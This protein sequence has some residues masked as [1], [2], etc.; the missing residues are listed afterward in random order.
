MVIMTSGITNIQL[1]LFLGFQKHRI[2]G[3]LL[4]IK[5]SRTPLYFGD[6][7]G[8]PDLLDG[9]HDNCSHLQSSGL[10]GKRVA[11]LQNILFSEK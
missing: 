6:I 11:R 5:P 10:E 4:H 9:D 3:Y 2:Y 1:D 7:S 8:H